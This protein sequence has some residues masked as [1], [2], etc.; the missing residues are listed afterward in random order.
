MRIDYY[1]FS[2][3]RL[4][5]FRDLIT[6]WDSLKSGR[7]WKIEPHNIR[8]HLGESIT[9]LKIPCIVGS[10]DEKVIVNA[11]TD[12]LLLLKKRL[13][14]EQDTDRQKEDGSYIPATIKTELIE[15]TYRTD[16]FPSNSIEK[17]VAENI[18]LTAP[19][20]DSGIIKCWLGKDGSGRQLINKIRLVI[21]KSINEEIELMGG[22][23][24]SY[25]T[26]LALINALVRSKE[27]LKKIKVRKI[28]YEKLELAVSFSMFFLFNAVISAV[29]E[30]LKQKTLSSIDINGIIKLLKSSL[31]PHSFISTNS[32]VLEYD[33]NPYIISKDISDIIA[34]IYEKIA[35]SSRDISDASDLIAEEIKG[36]P[37]LLCSL[38][39]I[40]RQ[41]RLRHLIAEYLFQYDAPG[42]EVHPLLAEIYQNRRMLH[43][44]FSDKRF[45]KE[46]YE[47]LGDIK[48]RF[49]RDTRRTEYIDRIQTFISTS[50]KTKF[51]DWLLHRTEMNPDYIVSIAVS[52]FI[53][54]KMD[55][56][57]DKFVRV[58]RGLIVDR[59]G[60][61]PEKERLYEYQRGRLYRFSSDERQ[62]LN[63]LTSTN[64]GLLFIDMKDFTRKTLKVKEASMADF[65]K[66]NF[67]IPILEAA[68]KYGA[69]GGI[70][71]VCKGVKIENFLGDAVIFS[72]GVA[73]L[74]SL[75]ADIRRLMRLYKDKL[76]KRFADIFD[77][78][79]KVPETEID[80]GLFI[81][82]GTE[83]EKITI[84][85]DYWGAVKVS[86]GEKINEAARGTAR[87][88]VIKTKMDMLLE[89]ARDERKRTD[90]AC[91]F[92]V[93]VDKTYSFIPF[94]ETGD[95]IYDMVLHKNP[96]TFLSLKSLSAINDI[97]N[98]GEAITETA[99]KA[100]MA[101]TK[102]TRSSF[103]KDIMVSQLDTDIQDRFFFPSEKLELW[104][105]IDTSDKIDTLKIFSKRGTIVFKGF[106]EAMPTTV[107]E[108]IDD[109]SEFFNM[110]VSRHFNK[111]YSEIKRL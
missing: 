35:P 77:H 107:Y 10:E 29:G 56:H 50:Y 33:T 39:G 83:A 103:K 11:I 92:K 27:V 59:R 91:P 26:L 13:D 84:N 101:E 46:L 15:R 19:V 60:E 99:L 31:S 109:S 74:L 72:G 34:P 62:I 4:S 53:A 41:N 44:A 20:V 51:L 95:R 18:L 8:F 58:M 24:T 40:Y 63:I 22:E 98:T 1:K 32:S 97:Y 9:D 65:M 52:G 81:S 68:R 104:F 47:R 80:A 66:G 54:Y 106:E 55:E 111:W 57:V 12:I 5:I 108:V 70:S 71:P 110:L 28:G 21:T 16:I 6:E 14:S 79:Q 86:I 90:I 43:S 76:I 3:E 105:S 96:E 2:N 67:Y 17:V 82:Y 89:K 48:T 73:N 7:V 94:S 64:E 75:A 78:S 85:N 100:Y 61:L 102:T 88:H 49:K 69:S 36:N 30:E 87:N 37:S 93:F 42:I 25:V 23:R 45:R 38:I